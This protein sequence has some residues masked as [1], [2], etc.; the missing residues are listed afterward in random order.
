MAPFSSHGQHPHPFFFLCFSLISFYLLSVSL[1]SGQQQRH[2][3]LS[4]RRSHLTTISSSYVGR[5]RRKRFC[6]SSLRPPLLL[7]VFLFLVVIIISL[8]L[9]ASSDFFI[10]LFMLLLT[11]HILPPLLLSL[12]HSRGGRRK[13]ISFSF[14]SPILS[15]PV[16]IVFLILIL[17]FLVI[18]IPPSSPLASYHQQFVILHLLLT[19][20]LFWDSCSS[21]AARSVLLLLAPCSLLLALV[22]HRVPM[23]IIVSLSHC[24]SWYIQYVCVFGALFRYVV[25]ILLFNLNRLTR[26]WCASSSLID[27]IVLHKKRRRGVS[28]RK[29]GKRKAAIKRSISLSSWSRPEGRKERNKANDREPFELHESGTRTAKTLNEGMWIKGSF[30]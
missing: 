1:F 21:C 19:S 26:V 22:W 20:S 24:S 17:L 3:R 29:D 7:I 10:I 28:K 5:G 9:L 23:I 14:L 27:T 25:D 18:I 4:H 13:N 15:C 11:V 16:V 8:L 6:F 2:Y 12:L 30:R